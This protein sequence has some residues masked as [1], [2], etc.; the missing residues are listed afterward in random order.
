MDK[1]IAVTRSALT[2]EESTVRNIQQRNLASDSLRLLGQHETA[3]V[4]GYSMAP[5]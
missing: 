4:K 5:L 2:A 1:L 3:L